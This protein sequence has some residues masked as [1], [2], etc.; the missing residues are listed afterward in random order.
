MIC[1]TPRAIQ[2]ALLGAFHKQNCQ[3]AS[4]KDL[5]FKIYVKY[6]DKNN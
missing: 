1:L 3:F 6:V 2:R 4:I 5:N